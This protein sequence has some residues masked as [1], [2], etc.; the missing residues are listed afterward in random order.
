MKDRLFLGS[1]AANPSILRWSVLANPEDWS[2][3]G[4]GSQ[5]VV[6]NDGDT[7]VGG[8]ELNN[9]IALL[10]KGYSIHQL[11][12][13]TAPFP[14]KP[15]TNRTGAA[16]KNAIVKAPDGMVYFINNEPRMKATDG[17]QVYDFPNYVNEIFDLI[18][19]ARL[20]FIYGQYY[21]N[22]NQIH[23]YCS[24][25][26]GVTT[27]NYCIIWDLTYKCWLRHT[28]GHDMNVACMA[29]GYRLFGGH[30]DGKIYEKDKTNIWIDASESN[31]AVKGYWYSSWIRGKSN[32]SIIHPKYIDIN[33]EA[34]TTETT[35]KYSYGF[36]YVQDITSSSFSSKISGSIW[37]SGQWDVNTWGS[38]PDSQKRIYLYGRGNNF[39]LKIYNDVQNDKMQINSVSLALNEVGATKEISN[40]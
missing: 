13:Q 6:T 4:S 9:D 27:N 22:L 39:Q 20:P 10:F 33:Y 40:V 12:V 1:S 36:N 15:L 28:T 17:Y 35:I 37:N 11:I 23:W 21:P 31:A 18:P 8:I 32:A 5:T 26:S 19:K 24:V 7:L 30:Y 2:G 3:T 38:R 29:Q 14:L 16:G 25:G 34:Q